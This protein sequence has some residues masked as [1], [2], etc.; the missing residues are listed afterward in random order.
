MIKLCTCDFYIIIMVIKSMFTE[1]SLVKDLVKQI[2][3]CLFW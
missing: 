3:R 1:L 2:R